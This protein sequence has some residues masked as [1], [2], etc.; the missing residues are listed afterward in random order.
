MQ[1]DMKVGKLS[2][3]VYNQQAVEILAA[4]RKLGEKVHS[5][6][7]THTHPYTYICTH[8]ALT[9]GDG[10]PNLSLECCTECL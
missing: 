7:L 4:L 3:D 10:V 8:A 5:H 2:E 6:T 1:R 9:S